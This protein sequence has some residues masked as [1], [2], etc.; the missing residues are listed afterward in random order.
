MINSDMQRFLKR[1][2]NA[3][4]RTFKMRMTRKLKYPVMFTSGKFRI[5]N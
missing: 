1:F 5:E 3:L 2:C 4:N